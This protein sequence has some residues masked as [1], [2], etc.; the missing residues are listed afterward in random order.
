M[1]EPIV[2]ASGRTA[3]VLA[4]DEH[5]V[6]KLFHA[7]VSEQ[8]IQDEFA[9]GERVVQ[10]GI[11]CP[12]PVRITEHGGR[13]GIIYTRVSG[14]TLLNRMLKRLWRLNIEAAELARIHLPIHQQTVSNMPKQKQRLMTD[15]EQ[16]PLLSAQEKLTVKAH[17]L[18]LKDDNK[19]CHGDYHPGNVIVHGQQEWIIDWMTGTEGNPAGDVARTFLI[20]KYGRLNDKP[21]R[22]LSGIASRLRIQI[23]N[24]YREAYVNHSD[25]SHTEIE[26]WMMP[27]AAARL[28]ER[29]PDAEKQALIEF[30]RQRL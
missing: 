18:Q 22:F 5:H 23:A 25:L 8:S 21:L 15:I 3:D 12:S 26:D 14:D 20:L 4:L 19:L 16:A 6:L 30:I 2:M 1:D 29:I 13:Q 11:A 7:T 17:L 27:V 24:K 10:L 28:V 9:I